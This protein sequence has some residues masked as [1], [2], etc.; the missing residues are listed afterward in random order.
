MI[1]RL[2]I[3]MRLTAWYLAVLCFCLAILGVVIFVGARESVTN[4]IDTDLR[5]RLA[6]TRTF[7]AQQ[8]PND[9]PQELQD[10]FQECYASQPGGALLQ[11]NNESGAWVFQSL[12]MQRYGI[13]VP[14]S[15]A[16]GSSQ[17]SSV[18][19]GDHLLRI[20]TDR[21]TV[22]GKSYVIQIA[23]DTTNFALVLQRLKW[24]LLI[25]TPLAIGLALAGG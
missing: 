9:S 10:E 2:P 8:I 4:I 7:I 23:T 18:V 19:K 21:T 24:L 12:S 22:N 25:S 20:I 3:R 6:A 1:R 11:I 5:A 15:V 16:G 17:F 13:A 14:Q